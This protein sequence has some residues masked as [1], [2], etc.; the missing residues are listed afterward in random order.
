MVDEIKVI[1]HVCEQEVPGKGVFTY[2]GPK[3]AHTS[4]HEHN[5][6]T[7]EGTGYINPVV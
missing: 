3:M 2:D 7:C 1:C 5:G 6:K 4:K